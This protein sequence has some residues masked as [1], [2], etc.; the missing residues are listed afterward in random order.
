MVEVH[1]RKKAIIQAKAQQELQAWLGPCHPKRQE[2]QSEEGAACGEGVQALQHHL[3]RCN[4]GAGPAS[5]HKETT[6]E[7]CA[8]QRQDP[9]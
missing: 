5:K 4:V 7:I 9:R 6:F 2:G 1:H 8:K 3:W